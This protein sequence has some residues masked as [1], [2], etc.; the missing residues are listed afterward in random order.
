M[1]TKK[2]API[3]WA[4]FLRGFIPFPMPYF[5]AVAVAKIKNP[6]NDTVKRV[7]WRISERSAAATVRRSGRTDNLLPARQKK[8]SIF[9]ESGTLFCGEYRSRTDDL[10]HA[11]HK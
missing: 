4:A 1:I 11:M 5:V 8:R 6:L 3:N 10:L 2:A 9:Q 7:L